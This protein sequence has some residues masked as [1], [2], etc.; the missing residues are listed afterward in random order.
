M[1]IVETRSTVALVRAVDQMSKAADVAYEGAFKVGY[2]L[3]AAVVRGDIGSVR[4]AIE[5]AASEASKHGELV[6]AHV[7]PQVYKGIEQRLSH[8]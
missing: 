6:S 1:G 4:I 7:I 5:A 8:F 3:T 2:F